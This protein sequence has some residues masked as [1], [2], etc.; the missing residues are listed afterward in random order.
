M[1]TE[2]WLALLGTIGA[3]IALTHFLAKALKESSDKTVAAKD[4]LIA[5]L[6]ETSATVLQ[7]N[8]DTQAK[9]NAATNQMSVSTKEF[10]DMKK[11]MII[12]AELTKTYIQDSE[13]RVKLLEENFGKVILK[14]K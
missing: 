8:Y 13:K 4:E 14:L 5:S 10:Y 6:K 11:Q 12:F 9:L 2:V 1:T 7:N 3:A